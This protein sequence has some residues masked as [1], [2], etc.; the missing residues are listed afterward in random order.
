MKKNKF[1]PVDEIDLLEIFYILWEKKFKIIG[2]ILIAVLLMIGFQTFSKLPSTVTTEIKPIP[3]SEFQKYR[4]LNAQYAKYNLQNKDE[5]YFSEI[6]REGFFNIF[7]NE[8]Q[9]KTNFKQEMFKYKILDVNEYNDQKTYELAVA[10]LASNIKIIPP[11]QLTDDKKTKEGALSYEH[12]TIVF[13]TYDTKKWIEILSSVDILANQNIQNFIEERFNNSIKL[14]E[15]MKN[16][17]LIDYQN[18]MNNLKM[19]YER[20]TEERL[21]FL[22]EQATIARKLDI[23]KSTLQTENISLSTENNNLNNSLAN[24]NTDRPFYMNGYLAIEEELNVILA[25]GADK[26]LFMG[27]LPLE[28]KIRALKQDQ[29]VNRIKNFF[30]LTPIIKNADEFKAAHIESSLSKVNSNNRMLGLLMAA[31]IGGLIGVIYFLFSAIK[32]TQN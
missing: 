9:N 3:A 13:E 32:P 22:K 16:N 31:L 1:N 7:I 15:T 29:S 30:S 21:A 20:E 2:F 18:Q 11:T 6:T 4:L 23:S 19:N 8:L 24:I 17:K 10:R 12:W 25:R 27:L 14:K 5:L 28:Q 26:R